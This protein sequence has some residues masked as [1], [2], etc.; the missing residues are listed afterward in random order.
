[1]GEANEIMKELSGRHE[2]PRDDRQ[3]ARARPAKSCSS[4]S[5]RAGVDVELRRDMWN[6]V[7]R[8][9]ES[10]V[11]DHPHHPIISRKPEEMADRVGVIREAN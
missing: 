7:R 8:L 2:A 9:R 5:L 6:M 4:T 1:V 10:G 3:G 11:T